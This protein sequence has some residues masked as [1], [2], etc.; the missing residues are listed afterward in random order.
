MTLGMI[1]GALPIAVAKRDLITPKKLFHYPRKTISLPPRNPY[2]TLT[3]PSQNHTLARCYGIRS[4]QMVMPVM[5]GGNQQF[6]TE[7]NGLII[8]RLIEMIF[9]AS[10]GCRNKGWC[11]GNAQNPF[12]RSQASNVAL[13]S[14]MRLSTFVGSIS[15]ASYL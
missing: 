15:L 9:P 13:Q 3:L 4:R 11:E 8:P 2:I 14:Y 7:K 10:G 12:Q 5:Q 6:G 1:S